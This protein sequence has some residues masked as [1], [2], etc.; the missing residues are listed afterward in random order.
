M[1]TNFSVIHRNHGHWDI[2]T[3]EGRA[4]R[5]RGTPGNFMAMDEREHPYPVTKFKTVGACMAFICDELM[6]EHIT[7]S[8][9]RDGNNVPVAASQADQI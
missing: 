1:T 3:K 6:N 9:R 8:P 2:T 7:E 5:I 4:F